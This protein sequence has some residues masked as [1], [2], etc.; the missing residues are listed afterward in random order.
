MFELNLPWPMVLLMIQVPLYVICFFSIL[1]LF[2]SCLLD[3]NTAKIVV[4]SLTL[5]A[6]F[7][8]LFPLVAAI[9]LLHSLENNPDSKFF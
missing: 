5:I 7:T 3:D 1:F 6:I 9:W 4:G 2:A 8:L